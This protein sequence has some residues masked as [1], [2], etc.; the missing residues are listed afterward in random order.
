MQS[1]ND[2]DIKQLIYHD[3]FFVYDSPNVVCTCT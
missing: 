1:S 3:S 2:Y